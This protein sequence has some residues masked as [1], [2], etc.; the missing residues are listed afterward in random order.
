[1]ATI[2][3]SDY[4]ISRKTGFVPEHP[5]QNLSDVYFAKW[6]YVA[7]NLPDLLKQKLLRQTIDDLPETEFSS[8]TLHSDDE[9]RRAYSILSFISQAYV[10]EGGQSEAVADLP[11]KL[12]IPWH[13]TS[14]HIGVP[15]AATYSATIFFNYR[16]KEPSGGLDCDNL[17][18]ALTFTGTE[19]ESW[20]Y[21]IHVMSELA[22]VPG[23]M[24]I[25]SGLY[26][27]STND[28]EGMKNSMFTIGESLHSMKRTLTRMYEQSNPRFYY[29][30]L[31]YFFGCP[32]GGLLFNGVFTERKTYR[33]GS[34][35]QDTA[36]PAF[37]IFL[38]V[39]HRENERELLEDFKT[40][41]PPKHR[42][43]LAALS[44]QPSVR[45]HVKNSG[46]SDLLKCYNEAVDALV[47]F[48]S[49]HRILVTRFIVNM[50]RQ[51]GENVTDAVKGMGGTSFMVFLKNLKEDT[52]SLKLSQC[53]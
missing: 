1:M 28:V 26:A 43:F 51:N 41:M 17:H 10:W 47:S 14:Q 5:V 19:D 24:A 35:A 33:G 2:K 30:T 52:V 22:A 20:F 11:A 45:E 21:M 23:I 39:K 34:G 9:W 3:L 4:D 18:A 44:E 8:N 29:N 37:G 49:E 16:L 42:A 46:N 50:K 31:R 38:G 7:Q 6:E 36:I 40:Y 15:P 13:T 12:A 32:E 27:M 53:K 48:R 25:E